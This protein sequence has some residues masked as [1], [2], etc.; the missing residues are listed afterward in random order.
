M[1]EKIDDPLKPLDQV[2]EPDIRSKWLQIYDPMDGIRQ[3]TLEDHHGEVA[4]VTLNE[5]APVGVRQLFENAKNLVLYSWFVY[6]FHQ[7]AELSA[8][9]ALEMA[10]RAKAKSDSPKWRG[11]AGKNKQPSLK[12]LL[13]E[14]NNFGWLKNQEFSVW[15]RHQQRRAYEKAMQKLIERM[16]QDGLTEAETPSVEEFEGKIGDE[17]YDYVRLL[18][19]SVPSTRNRLAYGSQSLHPN[20]LATLKLCAEIRRVPTFI[21]RHSV[22]A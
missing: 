13:V 18:S 17:N 15:R 10:L 5:S 2:T 21:S 3:K 14:A 6:R 19:R 12:T 7:P 22:T 16:Q 11:K 4:S 1:Q 9:G 20:S 8:Y